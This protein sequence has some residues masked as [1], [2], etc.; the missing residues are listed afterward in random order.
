MNIDFSNYKFHASSVKYLMTNPKTKKAQEAGELSDTTK[1]YLRDIFIEQVYGRKKPI[2]TGPMKKGTIVETNS[3]ELYQNV[4]GLVH[5]KNNKQYEN[6]FIIG[7]PDIVDIENDCIKDIKSSWD[8]WTF[9][10]VDE[11]SATSDYYWQI[12]SY[13]WMVGVKKGSLNY[14][15]VT[16]P[17][18]LM[19]GEYSKLAWS[20]G[21][22]EAEKITRLNHTYDDI[23]EEKRLKQYFY[24]FNE[25]QVSLL[26]A[27]VLTSRNYLNSLSI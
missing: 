10:G 16:T 24:E 8:I 1:T 12:F 26:Q 27:R 23:P 3:M 21:D 19:H 22:E 5:F 6:D 18:I 15:L 20:I 17:E 11:K 2:S 9:A 4:T 13:M 7:T 25:E 14:A